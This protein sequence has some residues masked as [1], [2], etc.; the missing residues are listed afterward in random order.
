MQRLRKQATQEFAD[1]VFNIIENIENVRNDLTK[2]KNSNPDPD[3]GRILLETKL[4]LN[5]SMDEL[6]KVFD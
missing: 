1:E 3:L 2:L 4:M 5:Q 6:R